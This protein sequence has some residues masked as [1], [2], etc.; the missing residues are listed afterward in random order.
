MLVLF[1]C[2]LQFSSLPSSPSSIP[3]KAILYL[4]QFPF[5][6]G[7]WE[8][9]AGARRVERQKGLTVYFGGMILAADMFSLSM[10]PVKAPP[11]TRAL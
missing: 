6:V 4:D 9:L 1:I 3:Q 10:A 7:Q 5:G 2:T 11:L 8:A